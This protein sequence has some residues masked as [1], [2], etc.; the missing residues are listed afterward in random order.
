MAHF[1]CL[2]IATLF[3][4]VGKPQNSFSSVQEPD[5]LAQQLSGTSGAGFLP[6]SS[7]D[8][9]VSD[10]KLQ[11]IRDSAISFQNPS[12]AQSAITGNSPMSTSDLIASTA[13]SCPNAASKFRKRQNPVQWL[14]D[15]IHGTFISPPSALPSAPSFCPYSPNTFTK[16]GG[17]SAPKFV[18]EAATQDGQPIVAPKPRRRVIKKKPPTKAPQ[19]TKQ[20]APEPM[21]GGPGG[22]SCPYDYPEKVCCRDQSIPQLYPEWGAFLDQCWDC[23]LPRCKILN[24]LF[25]ETQP[26]LTKRRPLSQPYSE[27]I[28]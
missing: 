25:T 15:R 14:W 24:P 23:E 21:A 10:S 8:E 20:N 18:P 11:D 5:V 26:W 3:V 1:L 19:E 4:A 9:Q 6:I 2:L 22:P 28:V 16:D 13:N 12:I 7:S 17:S 27:N